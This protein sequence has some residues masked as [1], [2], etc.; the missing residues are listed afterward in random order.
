MTANWS[1]PAYERIV[2]L[3]GTRSGLAFRP[4]RLRD[5]EAGIHRAM[6]RT[7]SKDVPEYLDGLETGRANLDDLVAE[8]TVNETYFFRDPSHFELIRE[9]LPRDRAIRAW[10]A[11]CASGEEPYSLAIL[12]DEIGLGGQAQILATDISRAAL[13]KA[14][15]ASYGAWSLRGVEA[16]VVD[17]YFRKVGDQH[18][19]DPRIRERVQFDYL[20]LAADSYPSLAN[21]TWR[22]DLI[23]CRNVFIYFDPATVRAVARR[24]TECL[25]PD[26]WLLL[27]PSDPPLADDLPLQRT[28][29]PA[30]LSYRRLA[31][32]VPP[33]AGSPPPP[34]PPVVASEPR[35]ATPGPDPLAEALVAFERG[36]YASVLELA[37]ELD[38]PDAAALC[39]RAA[40]NAHGAGA[41]ERIAADAARRHPL[42]GEIH[43]LHAAL[44]LDL[45][46]HAEAAGSARRAIYVDRG[47][48]V[49]HFLLGMALSRL[50]DVDGS[51]RAFGNARDLCA[52]MGREAL[53]PLG[54]GQSAGRLAEAAATQLERLGCAP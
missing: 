3:V 54:D 37:G 18:V 25:G 47:L 42:A 21:G 9:V 29:T 23:L 13:A 16:S 7:Q 19:L 15:A 26:G 53:V 48:A 30:G 45:H 35:V 33:E 6:A 49:A 5:A 52:R 11:G 34:T 36:T 43:V 2:R 38:D 27:G 39:I 22:M 17:R 40:A 31:L 10:S 4:S 14:R 20:N 8:L 28:I 24:L 12:F 32:P 51:R 44:L 46:R 1:E 50:A 41:A